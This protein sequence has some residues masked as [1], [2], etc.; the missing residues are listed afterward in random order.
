MMRGGRFRLP[1]WAVPCC[2]LLHIEAGMGE[3]GSA[4]MQVK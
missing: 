3:T 4:R 2:P 1:G